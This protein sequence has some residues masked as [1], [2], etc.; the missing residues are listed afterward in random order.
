MFKLSIAFNT[1]ILKH[2]KFSLFFLS[3]IAFTGCSLPGMVNPDSYGRDHQTYAVDFDPKN[4]SSINISKM[5]EGNWEN[6]GKV[7][8][9]GNS[10]FSITIENNYLIVEANK[11]SM[12]LP[13]YQTWINYARQE[14]GYTIDS[15]YDVFDTITEGWIY[16]I[17]LDKFP[18][19]NEENHRILMYEFN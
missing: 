1:L 7:S 17:D 14:L 18:L 4:L 3:L 19:V 11:A 2:L 15:E 5:N 9:N 6:I 12:D 16:E 13:T 8:N 10:R